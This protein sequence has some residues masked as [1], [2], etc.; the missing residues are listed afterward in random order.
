[1]SDSVILNDRYLLQERL[2]SG[3]MAVVYRAQDQM[4]ERTV[5]IKL[6]KRDFSTDPEFRER[7]RQE[8]KAVANLVMLPVCAL[9]TLYA[10]LL[11][12]WL[13]GREW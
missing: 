4:L 2:G 10:I 9:V 13:E 7:F 11:K 5:A 6:L 3:G 12:A 8:A 1:M